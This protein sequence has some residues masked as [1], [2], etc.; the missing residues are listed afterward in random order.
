MVHTMSIEPVEVV[1]D[2]RVLG[3]WEH[4]ALAKSVRDTR[5][6]PHEP[7]NATFLKMNHG[8]EVIALPIDCDPDNK[9]FL[10]VTLPEAPGKEWFC[11]LIWASDRLGPTVWFAKQSKV[12]TDL[13]SEI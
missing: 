1:R 4:P 8:I 5:K 12:E 2:P 13:F 3:W 10:E 7:E 6:A 11:I 9:N